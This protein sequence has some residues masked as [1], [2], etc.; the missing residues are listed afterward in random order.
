MKK[1]TKEVK[2]E[3]IIVPISWL[4]ELV[5]HAELAEK[6]KDHVMHLIGY[7]SSAKTLLK[8]GIRR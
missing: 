8:Y 2:E 5:R 7:C 3:N 4:S 1:K 6:N